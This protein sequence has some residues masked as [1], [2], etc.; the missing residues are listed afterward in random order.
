MGLAVYDSQMEKERKVRQ[1]A[2]MGLHIRGGGCKNLDSKATA[3][4]DG[5]A[6][7]SRMLIIAR[8]FF[9]HFLTSFSCVNGLK[10]IVAEK[11]NGLHIFFIFSNLHLFLQLACTHSSHTL[12]VWLFE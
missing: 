12:S 9:P 2:S 6:L 10:S 7:A 4:K 3:Q 11:N 1:L 5:T 8:V